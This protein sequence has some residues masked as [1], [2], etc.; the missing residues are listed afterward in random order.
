LLCPANA[1]A[2]IVLP[3]FWPKLGTDRVEQLKYGFGIGM[4][5]HP[6]ALRGS[7]S[8]CWGA[9]GWGFLLF[10]VVFLKFGIG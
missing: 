4:L 3:A 2:C 8:L 6:T 7:A 9:K 1:L 5:I 10:H